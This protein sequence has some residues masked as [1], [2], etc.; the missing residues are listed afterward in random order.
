MLSDRHLL[1]D[2]DNC[3]MLQ[4]AS[5]TLELNSFVPLSKRA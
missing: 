5:V 2:Q 3:V 4:V 1:L